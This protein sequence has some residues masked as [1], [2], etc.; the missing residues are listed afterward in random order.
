[1]LMYLLYR[2]INIAAHRL[3]QKGAMGRIDFCKKSGL[4]EFQIG[5]ILAK[6]IFEIF[7]NYFFQPAIPGPPVPIAHEM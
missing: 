6:K 2:E 1:M 3:L 5:K 4:A 7:K